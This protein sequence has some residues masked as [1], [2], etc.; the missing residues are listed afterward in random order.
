MELRLFAQQLETCADV[1]DALIKDQLHRAPGVGAGENSG[2]RFLFFDG[3]LFEDREVLLVRSHF[4][5]GKTLVTRHQLLQSCIGGE[6]SLG[7]D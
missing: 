5:S 6:G 3:F 4:A 2:K 7:E 1:S